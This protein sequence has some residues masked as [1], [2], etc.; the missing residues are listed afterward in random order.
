MNIEVRLFAQLRKYLP[1][2][3]SQGSTRIDMPDGAT[4]AD[5]LAE[6]GIPASSVNMALVDGFHEA[7]FRQRLKDRCTLSVF[8]PIAGG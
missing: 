8:P 5:A 3:S 6:I 4:I 7:D 2:G 1:P